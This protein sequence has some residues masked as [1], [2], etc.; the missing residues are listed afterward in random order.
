VFIDS[1]T[2]YQIK[3]ESSNK[4]NKEKNKLI[5]KKNT[6]NEAVPKID[7]N[8]KLPIEQKI[9]NISSKFSSEN[10]ED[11]F[12]IFCSIGNRAKNIKYIFQIFK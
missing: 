12:D 3:E 4:N 8:F 10:L 9:S 6:K 11:I 7:I 1:L 5:S 2:V